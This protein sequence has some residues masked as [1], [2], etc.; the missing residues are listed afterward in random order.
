MVTHQLAHN[1][2]CTPGNSHSK[3]QLLFDPL[4]CE[5]YGY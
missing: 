1:Q 2:T 5:G 3:T 4:V